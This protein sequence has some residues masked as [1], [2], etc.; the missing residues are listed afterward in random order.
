MIYNSF[1]LPPD[2]QVIRTKPP[3]LALPTDSDRGAFTEKLQH[4][5]NETQDLSG[6]VVALRW[7]R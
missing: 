6:F 1:S 2:T 5:L 4:L 3:S 7:G